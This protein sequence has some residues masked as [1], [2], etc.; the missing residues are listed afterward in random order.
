MGYIA[1]IADAVKLI[2]KEELMRPG[3]QIALLPGSDCDVGSGAGHHRV[4]PWGLPCTCSGGILPSTSLTSTWA[5]VY[6]VCGLDCR[7][8]DCAG[9]LELQQQVRHDGGLRSTAQM[10]SY[11]SP[12]ACRSSGDLAGGFGPDDEIVAAQKS[13]VC[14]APTGRDGHLPDRHPGEV[15]RAPFD[16]PEAEQELTAGYHTEY[17]A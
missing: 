1:A 10:I 16:M 9:R 6:H 17:S 14:A 3:R 12:L 8:R 4:V 15:N 5:F 13:A 7:L 2:F 11:E